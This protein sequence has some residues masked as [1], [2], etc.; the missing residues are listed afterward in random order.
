MTET[1]ALGRISRRWSALG[2]TTRRRIVLGSLVAMSLAAREY[3][4]LLSTS[5]LF[6]LAE[7]AP[8]PARRGAVSS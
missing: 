7:L 8:R 6:A 1:A 5:A 2:S 4:L 3:V